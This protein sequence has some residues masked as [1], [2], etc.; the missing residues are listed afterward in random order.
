M[1][2]F[3]WKTQDTG[4]SISNSYSSRGTF[5]VYMI[6]PKT[7]EVYKEENYDGYGEFGNKDFYELL[8][9]INGQEGRGA[10]IDIE[11]GN[12]RENYIFPVLVENLEGWEKYKGR[13]PENCEF[14]G[15]F[16]DEYD[17]DE[18]DDTWEEDEEEWD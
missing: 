17:D 8:A 18:E 15:Y 16:Y 11:C 13:R 5:T 7:G 10:G 14:Q 2:F 12:N 3:S 4:R 1:G 6:N 9:E